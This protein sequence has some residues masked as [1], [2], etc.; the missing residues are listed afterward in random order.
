MPLIY[1]EHNIAYVHIGHFIRNRK[2]MGNEV[3]LRACHPVLL[4]LHSVFWSYYTTASTKC[5]PTLWNRLIQ[6]VLV[7]SRL[8]L[9]ST[10]KH[11]TTASFQI[12]IYHSPL[13]NRCA[14]LSELRLSYIQSGLLIFYQPS[15]IQ[16][17]H[18]KFLFGFGFN[19][20]PW[21]LF[22]QERNV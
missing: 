22:L 18:K 6:F 21:I 16:R 1:T 12:L 5:I 9:D 19:W 14:N 15:P 13:I 20:N 3:T 8:V 10:L 2:W 11:V 7:F 4:F 17:K